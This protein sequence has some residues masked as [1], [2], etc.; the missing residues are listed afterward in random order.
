MGL[1]LNSII[2]TVFAFF[3]FILYNAGFFSKINVSRNKIPKMTIAGI[4]FKGPYQNTGKPFKELQQKIDEAKIAVKYCG[5]YFDNV[6]K[7]PADQLRSFVGAVILDPTEET[8][9][10]LKELDLEVFETEEQKDAIHAYHP[11]GTIKV[12]ESLSFMFAPMRVYPAMTKY[13]ETV[14]ELKNSDYK[15]EDYEGKNIPCFEIY[16]EDTK[17]IHFILQ[18]CHAYKILTD[19]K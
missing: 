13:L 1:I 10:K 11:M 2:F 5:L 6:Q 12:F 14:P 18:N 17:Q 4:R 9:A 19:F 16:D 8:I 3:G 7:V 15:T